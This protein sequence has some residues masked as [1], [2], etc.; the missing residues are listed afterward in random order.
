ML[1][2]NKQDTD[3]LTQFASKNEMNWWSS[4]NVTIQTPF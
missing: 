1:R 2:E 3:A 4:K